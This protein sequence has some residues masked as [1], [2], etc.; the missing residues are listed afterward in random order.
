MLPLVLGGLLKIS[1]LVNKILP[2][3]HIREGY[4]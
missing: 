2:E 1:L 4:L 3:D